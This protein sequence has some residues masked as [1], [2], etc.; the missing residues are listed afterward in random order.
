MSQFHHY[1]DPNELWPSPPFHK[2][3]EGY[4]FIAAKLMIMA[5]NQCSSVFFF[6]MM[7][8]NV[9]LGDVLFQHLAIYFSKEQLPLLELV[10]QLLR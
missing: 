10:Q 3:R 7:N 1:G 5:D 4:I 6:V 9:S 2:K 8:D